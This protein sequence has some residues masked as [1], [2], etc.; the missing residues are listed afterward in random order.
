[1]EYAKIDNLLG[2]AHLLAL[3]QL[4]LDFISEALTVASGEART[5]LLAV[6]AWFAEFAGWLYQDAGTPQLAAHWTDRAFTWAQAA[7]SPLMASYVLMR[8]SNQVSESG[9]ATSALALAR[10]ALRKQDRLSPRAR[11]LV[12]RQEAR[13]YA[14]LGETDACAR[15]LD[16]AQ[17]GASDRGD[18]GEDDRALTAYCTPSY[19][20]GEAAAC[21][22]ILGQHDK[23]VRILE[24][25]LA[26]WP[27]AYQRDRGLN[28]ARLAVAHAAAQDPERACA[29]AQEAATIIKDANSA[30]ALAELGRLPAML[31]PWADLSAV[32]DLE[33]VLVTLR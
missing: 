2:P 8:R 19:I 22:T 30:R 1:V 32:A 28:L 14:L 33:E 27:A 24:H 13:G 21:W 10:A 16:K 18:Y 23:A 12:L 17:E 25:G 5:E 31:T 4:H 3:V 6:G 9:D 7:E 29:A 15:A 11:A 20:E 26:A